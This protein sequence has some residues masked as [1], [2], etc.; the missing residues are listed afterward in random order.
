M[1]NGNNQMSMRNKEQ[2]TK[3]QLQRVETIKEQMN[4]RVKTIKEQMRIEELSGELMCYEIMGL[5][6]I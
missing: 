3:E 1:G 5:N 6:I 4:L 2:G